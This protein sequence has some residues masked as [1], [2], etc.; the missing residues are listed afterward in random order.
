MALNQ[1]LLPRFIITI[2]TTVIEKSPILSSCSLVV[3]TRLL[4]ILKKPKPMIIRHRNTAIDPVL[5]PLPVL[6]QSS[7]VSAPGRDS[8][9]A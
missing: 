4:S 7:P 8:V 6:L 9:P 2:I 1:A 3:K 5:N